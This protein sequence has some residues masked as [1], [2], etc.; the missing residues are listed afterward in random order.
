MRKLEIG[1]RPNPVPGYEQLHEDVRW[2]G[3]RLPYDD[4]S[5]DEVYASHVIEHVPWFRVEYAILEACRVLRRG[6]TI[7][8]HTVDFGYL[9]EC[10]L[11]GRAGDQWQA[12]G[13]NPD[14][15]PF[16]WIASRIFS[17]GP[18]DNWH[19]GIFDRAYLTELLDAAGFGELESVDHPKGPNHGPMNLGIR[20]RKP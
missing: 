18:G 2:G 3:D 19:L 7:E 20:G 1:G 4:E 11:R 15:H 5:F 10:Y 14:L 13:H 8:I 17:V 16:R 6:G 12:R 9:V